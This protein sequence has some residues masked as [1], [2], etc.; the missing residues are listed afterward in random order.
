MKV[1]SIQLEGFDIGFSYLVSHNNRRSTDKAV[2]NFFRYTE[3][4]GLPLNHSIS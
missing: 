1:R 4:I 3:L 2:H